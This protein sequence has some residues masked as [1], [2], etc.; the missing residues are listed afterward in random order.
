M[1]EAAFAEEDSKELAE[2]LDPDAT[3][4]KDDDKG[5]EEVVQKRNYEAELIS[6]IKGGFTPKS[7]KDK[8]EDYHENDIAEILDKI[9]AVERRKIYRLLEKDTLSSVFEYANPEDVSG[10]LDEMDI[11]KAAQILALM[12]TDVAVDILRSMEKYK[13][14]ILIELLDDESKNDIALIAS[15]D[16]DEIGSRMSTNY[17]C[18]PDSSTVK[19]AMAGLVEQAEKNDNISTIFVVDDNGIFSG[20]ID[21][22]ELIIAREKTNLKDIIITSFPYVYGQEDIDVCIERLKDYSENSIPV[23]D[24]NNRILGVITSQSIV[25]L[26]NEEMGEDYAKFAGLTAEEDLNEPIKASLAKRLPWLLILLG[27]GIVISSVA[28]VMQGLVSTL[29]VVMAFQSLILDMAGNSG[30]QSLAVTIRVLTDD[31]L[32]LKTK[33]RLVFKEMRVG[34][35]NGLIVGS[36]AFLTLGLYTKLLK[37]LAWKIAFSISGC[38]FISLVLAMTVASLVGTTIPLLFKKIKIDPAVASGP[39]ITSINDLVAV[40]TYYGLCYLI[41]VQMMGITSL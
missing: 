4:E 25:E 27:V 17:I 6:I 18:I 1:K 7:L 8:L 3:V 16:E 39:L 37:G 40:V 23:L 11:K 20:A 29:V 15:F 14:V 12:E 13:R 34:F 36:L 19:E 30:T 9:T 41:L 5:E 2:K 28:G 22:K 33:V 26:V 35:M 21:L 31:S 10:Y 32:D 38:A 24:N